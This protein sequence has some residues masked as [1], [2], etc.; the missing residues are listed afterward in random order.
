VTVCDGAAPARRAA[1]R[2]ATVRDP[3]DVIRS[4]EAG[5]A[6]APRPLAR[7]LVALNAL[8]LAVAVGILILSPVTISSPV[9]VE[10]I[11]LLL[12]GLTAMLVIDVVLTRR[13]LLPLS[14]LTRLMERVDPLLPGQRLP[15]HDEIAEVAE[16]TTSFNAML[17]RLEAERAQSARRALVA[18]ESERRRVAQELHDAV[19]QTL[20]VLLLELEDASRRVGPEHRGRIAAMQETVRGGIEDTRRIVA[21]LRPGV[22]DDLGLRSALTS[23]S[24]ALS[25]RTA[26]PIHRH[27]D[28][29][30]PALAPDAELVVYRVAQEALTNAVRHADATRVDLHLER[31][32]AGVRLR[33][34]DDGR[35]LEAD[36]PPGGGLRGMRE[37]ALMI[38]A[39]LRIGAVDG[40]GAEVCLEVAAP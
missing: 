3:V 17:E 26:L 14:R 7:R 31:T 32:E 16:L 23:L 15:A 13:A 22:L 35:G 34:A 37:R 24:G 20:T 25:E 33:V 9:A 12:L 39:D 38:G 29:A 2:H 8:V 5:R 28:G 27:F 1:P 6:R 10:E 40:G 19:G 11:A 21:E 36:G 30:L 4:P 18:Q